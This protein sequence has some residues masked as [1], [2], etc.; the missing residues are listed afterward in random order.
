MKSDGMKL[1]VSGDQSSS[2]IA[3]DSDEFTGFVFKLQAN[4]DPRHR[5]RMA[6]IRVC[7]GTFRKGMKVGHSR[8]KKTIN[9]SSAQRYHMSSSDHN[10]T[11]TSYPSKLFTHTYLTN[12]IFLFNTF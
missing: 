2:T 3:P 9:L 7:S 4:L 11:D 12:V 8:M 5:D 1:L 6:F 10:A